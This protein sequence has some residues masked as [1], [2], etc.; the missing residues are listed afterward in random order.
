MSI[1]KDDVNPKE[2]FWRHLRITEK[3]FEEKADT[4]DLIICSNVK[5]DH[6]VHYEAAFMLF[7]MEDTYD[8]QQKGLFVL[9][10][11]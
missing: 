11:S 5:K 2:K 6:F 9:S 4:G 10:P 3:E 8:M 1:Y 7:K